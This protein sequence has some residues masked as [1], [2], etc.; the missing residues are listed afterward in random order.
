MPE[1]DFHDLPKP[2]NPSLSSDSAGLRKL[3]HLA[4]LTSIYNPLIIQTG[5]K[6]F[7][8]NSL[9]LVYSGLIMET[10]VL[11]GLEKGIK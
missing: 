10:A 3:C 9:N 11:F 7:P 1:G 5:S 4:K 6:I 8:E 2:F